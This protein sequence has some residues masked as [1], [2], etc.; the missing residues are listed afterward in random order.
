MDPQDHNDIENEQLQSDQGQEEQDSN[1]DQGADQD[2]QLG[3]DSATDSEPEHDENT[4]GEDEQQRINQEKIDAAI[5]R[6]H[7]KFREE[8]RRRIAAEQQL[9]QYGGMQQ[10]EPEPQLY[11]IDEYADDIQAEVRKRDQSLREHLQWQQRQQQRQ[12]DQQSYQQQTYQQQ[13]QQ[14]A[15]QAQK[16]FDTAKKDGIDQ[17]Q[18]NTA[19]QTVGQYQLGQEVA[20]YLMSDDRGHQVTM[21]LAKQ[22]TLLADL[23]FMQP[24]ERILH[25]ERNVRSK[26]SAPKPRQSK[27]SQPPKRVRGRASDVSDRFPLTGGRVKVE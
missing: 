27:G 10:N 17:Q 9:Q 6:Q 8:Q 4:D 12:A 7:A 26:V 21:A 1:F 15:E 13:Q 25:I 3:A 18:L 20:Q 22:P 11:E 2:Q 19:I 23:A 14:A 5:A 24:H 16:F